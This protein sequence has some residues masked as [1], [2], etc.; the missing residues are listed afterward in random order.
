MPFST[1]ILEINLCKLTSSFP[2]SA[3]LH[4]GSIYQTVMLTWLTNIQA[5]YRHLFPIPPLI[6]H[7]PTYFLLPHL[8]PMTPHISHCPTYFPLPHLFAIA[9]L[10]SHDP[11]YFLLP[12]I[13]PIAPLICHCPT[14]LP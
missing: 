2:C 4:Q 9:P 14:Y 6:C 8:F 1:R 3:D 13:F 7:D 10:I 11:T 12:H 5:L